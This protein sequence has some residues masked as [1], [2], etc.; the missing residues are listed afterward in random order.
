MNLKVASTLVAAAFLGGFAVQASAQETKPVGL[1]LRAGVFFPASTEARD[2][3]GDTWFAFGGEFKLKDLKFGDTQPGYSSYLSLSAD[4]LS[5]GDYKNLPVL[6]NYV[7]RVNQVYYTAGAGV[8]FAEFP[9]G[10]LNANKSLFAYSVGVGYDFQQAST[11]VFIEAR[12]F[13][14]GESRLDGYVVYLGVRL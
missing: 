1:S 5:K 6:I 11:P 10:L 8:G 7:G 4:Y 12:Y 3:E 9:D 14:S 2:A 13:G